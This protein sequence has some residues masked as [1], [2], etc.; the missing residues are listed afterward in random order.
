MIPAN[1]RRIPERS[2]SFSSFYTSS[3]VP[4]ISTYCSE[5]ESFEG[6]QIQEFFCDENEHSNIERA[7][8]TR[9][10]GTLDWDITMNSCQR[11][12]TSKD[13]KCLS[14][15][16]S[17]WASWSSCD[18]S[19][20][21]GKSTCPGNRRRTRKCEGGHA[22]PSCCPPPEKTEEEKFCTSLDCCTTNGQFTCND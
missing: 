5:T 1:P 16:W 14:Y 22:K 20:G 17:N 18:A 6:A 9:K 19:C 15:Q 10:N 2:Q 21:C 12:E 7:V 13:V 3:S 11:F 4:Q 8:C